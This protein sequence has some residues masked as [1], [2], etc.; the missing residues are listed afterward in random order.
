ML[1]WAGIRTLVSWS[2]CR[3]RH[4]QVEAK[5][6]Q[7]TSC[8]RLSRR[9]YH[10]NHKLNWP[11]RLDFLPFRSII[12]QTT[13]ISNVDHG[14]TSTSIYT[15]DLDCYLIA[16]QRSGPMQLLLQSV[17]VLRLRETPMLAGVSRRAFP[18]TQS[19]PLAK[20]N[21]NAVSSQPRSLRPRQNQKRLTRQV[22]SLRL[23]R[24][25]KYCSEKYH[26]P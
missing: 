26:A 20:C 13:H 11:N 19:T 24:S 8:T 22:P 14:D 3:I 21:C 6:V 17:F 18:C 9:V 5:A 23:G 16:D 1:C 15:N 2:L 25:R 4:L 12:G 10:F 7:T